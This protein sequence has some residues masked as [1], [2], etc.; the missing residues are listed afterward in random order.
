MK[1]QSLSI[2]IPTVKCINNCPF[3]VSRM[4]D[5]N[6]DMENGE[7]FNEDYIERLEYARDNG[8]NTVI[9]TGT[10]EALQN[11]PFITRFSNYNKSLKRPF[12]NIELQ[13]TGVYLNDETLEWLRK[14]IRVKT[15]SLSVSDLFDNE[16]N[17]KIMGVRKDLRFDMVELVKK[18]KS[19]GFNIRLSL[20]VLDNILKYSIRKLFDKIFEFG[21]DQA[22]FRKLWT[23]GQNSNIDKWIDKHNVDDSYF[24]LINIYI[25]NNGRLLGRLTFGALQYEIGGENGIS[26]VLD[27]DCMNDQEIKDEIKY[28][29]LR[30]NAKLYTK[31]NS[32]ASL[33][34]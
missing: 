17:M 18:I 27:T 19:Y 20:N 12:Y 33:I 9:L 22:T 6:Y 13:T 29:I 31:W 21:F 28:L 3:C 5:N 24:K 14:E 30:E 32:K 2:V 16:N 11:K 10:G 7:F 34:F 26:V 23:S 1:I 15:I 25:K 8:T 4:H